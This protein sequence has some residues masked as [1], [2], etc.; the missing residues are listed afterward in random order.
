MR[1]CLRKWVAVIG[2]VMFLMAI[3]LYYVWYIVGS[4]GLP[5]LCTMLVP[6]FMGIIL[7]LAGWGALAEKR[8]RGIE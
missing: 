7:F 8:L 1:D 3:A 4:M 2:L 5:Q 6:L